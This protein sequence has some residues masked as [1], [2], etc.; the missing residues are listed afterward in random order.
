MFTQCIRKEKLTLTAASVAAF[1]AEQVHVATEKFQGVQ[2]WLHRHGR[3]KGTAAIDVP[4]NTQTALSTR[5]F[6]SR[7]KKV[8][9][10]WIRR[11]VGDGY[12]IRVGLSHGFI[13]CFSMFQ[14]VYVVTGEV[15][16]VCRTDGGGTKTRFAER[17]RSRS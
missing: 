5:M 13:I 10:E 14:Y 7:Q 1:P 8:M 11:R 2:T 15:G 4:D 9:D 17:R 3:A 12:F 6:S 16:C